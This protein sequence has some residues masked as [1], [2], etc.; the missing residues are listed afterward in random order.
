MGLSAAEKNRRKRERKKK[1]KEEQRQQEEAAAKAVATSATEDLNGV[2]N[3]DIEIEYV[4]E[5]PILNLSVAEESADSSTKGYK[6][7]GA[8]GS[9]ST[10][11]ADSLP[12]GLP[13]LPG[14]ALS[15]QKPKQHDQGDSIQNVLRRFNERALVVPSLSA[16][17]SDDEP[18]KSGRGEHSDGNDDDSDDGSN[19]SDDEGYGNNKTLSNRKL[20]ELTRPTVAELKRRVARPDLVEAHDITAADPDFLI[21]LKAIP[22]TTKVPRHW[23]RKRKYLQ[24]K[25]R[26]EKPPFKLPDFIVKTGIT[27]IRDTVA[28]DEAKQSAK[29]KNRGRVNPKMGNMDVDYAVLYEA[30]FKYQTKPTDLT[31]FGDLYYEGKELETSTDIQPGGPYSKKLLEALGMAGNDSAPPWLFNMQRYGPPP[32]YPHLSIPGLTAPL[33]KGGTYGFHPGGFGKPPVDAYGRPLYGGNPF[34]PPGSG[35]RESNWRELVTSDG[36]TVLK[37]PWGSLPTGEFASSFGQ[38][39]ADEEEGSDEESNS[40]EEESMEESDADEEE[41]NAEGM[42]SVLPPPPTYS[43][44]APRDLRKQPAGDETPFPENVPKRLYQVLETTTVSEGSA[45]HDGVFQ[46]EIQYVVPGAE[47]QVVK[48]AAPVPEGAE[49]V[50]SKAMAPGQTS[51]KKRKHNADDEDALDKNF[52]F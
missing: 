37:D 13:P 33:P 16:V 2:D 23:G 10:A 34:D 40:E 24:G 18:R 38:N 22:G 19:D 41:A 6:K 46:S 4:A 3:D 31:K 45:H 35:K 21:A 39:R 1:E 20:R 9:G 30:F 8:K 42:A 43:A 50:L 49:S 47:T 17:V 36:K 51:S 52:K 11:S 12:D 7:A 26:C 28:E 14:Q 29:Q 44:T 15:S 25:R 5:D 48:P 32:S 27:E